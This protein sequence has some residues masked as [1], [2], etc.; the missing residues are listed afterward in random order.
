MHVGIIMFI[1]DYGLPVT[2]L[3]K[4]VEARGFESLWIPEHSHIPISRKSQYPAGGDLP[5]RYYD[6]MDPFPVLG[7]AE[8]RQ[9]V[10]VAPGVESALI[11]PAFVVHGVAADV[12]HPVDAR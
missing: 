8:V 10:G 2:Q 5:K 11:T 1:T 3:A 4:E 9:H 7:A 12:D 6:C